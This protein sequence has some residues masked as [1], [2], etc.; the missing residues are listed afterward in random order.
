MNSV[1]LTEKKRGLY[2]EEF[3]ETNSQL[4]DAFSQI[5][6]E[7]EDHLTAINENTN[8][9]Q[10]NYELVCNIDQ[11]LNK[12]TE[13]LDKF[14]LFLQ[15][16][17]MEIEEK[18]SFKPIRL[19][20][21][22]QEIFLVLYTQEEVKGSVTYLDIARRVCLPEDIVASYIANML[23]KGV[24]ITKKYISNEAHLNLNPKFKAKQAKENI[25]QIEQ[26]TLG[27]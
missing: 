6:D 25:L 17:G 24:P 20:K 26:R 15:K 4:H 16:Q 5:K 10:A 23:Q 1:L 2:S 13:R 14:E 7:F 11:K 19:S 18:E 22:E 21:R 27:F 12:L 8:E 9:I 3:K